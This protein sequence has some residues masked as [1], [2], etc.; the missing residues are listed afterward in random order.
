MAAGPAAQSGGLRL[1][2][3]DPAA[4]SG[5]LRLTASPSRGFAGL[6]VG[7]AG[8]RTVL[9]V[10]GVIAISLAVGCSRRAGTAAAGGGAGA[11]AGE[12]TEAPPAVPFEV[13]RE[14]SELTFFW[15]DGHGGIHAVQ[16][17]E[18]VPE[19]NR[20]RVRV[21]PPRP[22]MRAPGWV[23]VADLRAAG[24]NGR[25]AVRP[26]ASE[27]FASELA[28]LTGL[29]AAMSA[30]ATPRPS[31]P[32]AEPSAAGGNTGILAPVA[33]APTVAAGANAH[34]NVV[35]YGATWCGACHQATEYLRANNIPF[36]EHDI[37]RE[38]DAAREV[39]ARAREQGLPVGSIPIIDVRGRLLVGFNAD[40]IQRALT[41]G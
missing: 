6:D 16:R 24:A 19:A 35:V 10:V 2:G 39:Y 23:F 8:R 5:G 20:G 17:M 7:R 9:A 31:A 15:F 11:G 25:F 28:Q 37:E 34:A 22:E 21:E 13:R 18:D 30:P 38:P 26:V 33:R 12:G 32:S 36:I 27:T 41:G 3:P 29:A 40:A 1:T 4:R 14:S